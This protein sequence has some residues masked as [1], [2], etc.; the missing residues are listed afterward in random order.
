MRG[1]RGVRSTLRRR[2]PDGESG[3]AMVEF[4]L[5]LPV[6]LLMILIMFEFGLA[7]SHHLTLGYA[8]REA[9]RTGSALATGG[10]TNCAGGGDP[11]GV[12][13]QLIAALQRVV[14][15]PGSDVRMNEIQEV[16]IFKA[17]ASGGQVGGLVNVWRYAPGGGLDIDPGPGIDRLDFVESSVAWPA[18][19]RANN[20]NPDSLGVRI[21]YRYQLATPLAALVG[22]MGGSQA[23]EFQLNDQTVMAL[24]PTS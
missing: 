18:C 4:S 14:K 16:R 20:L 15:S 24:N 13:R 9:A 23:P 1:R 11:A 2:Q 22:L 6:F 10:T 17:D 8:S 3:V 5:I 19:A 21:L 12:D 7:F